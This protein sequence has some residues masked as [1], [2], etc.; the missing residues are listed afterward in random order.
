MDRISTVFN[1]WFPSGYILIM[2][3]CGAFYD[4][5]NRLNNDMEYN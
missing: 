4:Q 5:E 2:W 3:S 1:E